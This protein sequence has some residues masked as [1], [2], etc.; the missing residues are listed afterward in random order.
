VTIFALSSG[1]PPAGIAVVRMSGS[2]AGAALLALA[3]TLPEPR[4]ASLRALHDVDGALLDRAL[5]LWFPGP[6][7]ATG[8]DLAELHLHGGRA[9]VDA[10]LTALSAQPGLRLAE[11]GEFTRRALVNGR[12]DLTEAE[13]LAELLSAETATQHRQALAMSGGVVG[14]AVQGWQG[15][16]LGLAARA[17]ALL[18]FADEDDVDADAAAL[19]V[20]TQDIGLLVEALRCWL[21]VP[22]AE[23]LRDGIEVVIAG[24]PNSGKST[25]INVLSH[26]EV[27]IVSP[28]AGTTRDVIETALALDGIPFRFADTAGLHD[29]TGDSIE[30]IG[31]ARARE[32]LAVADLLLW[33]GDPLAAP[34]HDG[35]IRIAARA[36]VRAAEPDWPTVVAATDLVL[37]AATGEGMAALRELLVTRARQLLPREGEVAL[38]RRQRA[39]LAAAHDALADADRTDPL[40]MAESLRQARLAFDRLTGAAGTESMLD[41]L[42]GRF[43]I[44][45]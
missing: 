19:A 30:A 26:R 44:G 15:Q 27:A 24:P 10:V 4:R 5:T 29:G 11:P 41:A 1:L 40:L 9:V 28:L 14:Q 23:R 12:I 43:C 13:G 34:Q 35:L 22:P 3:G 25:L 37:S 39:E 18:D 20:I 16:L 6:E 45:K 2:R 17:E 33:L 38:N 8:E 21:A 31:M 36:D 7:T 32:R 42:F